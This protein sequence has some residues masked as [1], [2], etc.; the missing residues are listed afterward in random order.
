[1]PS[2]G[3][4]S[5]TVTIN[6]MKRHVKRIVY[7]IVGLLLIIISP[8]LGAIPGPGGFIVF[9]AG[10]SILAVH[11]VWAKQLLTW[12]KTN[13][14]SLLDVIFTNDKRIQLV[15]DAIGLSLVT[16]SVVSALMLQPPLVYMLPVMFGAIGLFWLLYNRKRYLRLFKKH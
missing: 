4:K 10:L 16:A 13:A 1:M 12:A 6:G 11:N 7:D 15:H 3:S 5:F 14:N 9:F 8:F 2:L